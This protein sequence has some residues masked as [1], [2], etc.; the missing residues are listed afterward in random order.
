MSDK[1][2]SIDSVRIQKSG[3]PVVIGSPQV[4]ST[5]DYRELKIGKLVGSG[6]FAGK[7]STFVNSYHL[8]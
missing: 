8:Y 1:H 4:S 5:I 6:E 2:D 3:S 7:C